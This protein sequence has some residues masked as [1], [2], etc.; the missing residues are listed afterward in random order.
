MLRPL[1]LGV[2]LVRDVNL[3]HSCRCLLIAMDHALEPLARL[4][5]F[6]LLVAL[7]L[8]RLAEQRKIEAIGFIFLA[9]VIAGRV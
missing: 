5:G 3:Q 7:I 4:R 8:C 2:L 9:A 6:S 1:W